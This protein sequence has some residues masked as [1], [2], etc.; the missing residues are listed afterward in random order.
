MREEPVTAAVKVALLASM[1][2]F[3][4]RLIHYSIQTNHLHLLV[5]A[6]NRAALAKGVKGLTV[7]V[8]KALNQLCQRKGKV[9]SDRYHV[10]VLRKP[11]ETRKALHYVL[12]N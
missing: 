10:H 4:F 1:N 8:A 9:F 11:L 3:G 12:N 5:E 6:N 2:R 7:R